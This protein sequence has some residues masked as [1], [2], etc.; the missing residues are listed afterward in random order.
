M[1]LDAEWWGELRRFRVL[2]EAG[3]SVSEIARE[4]DLNRRT[5]AKYLEPNNPTTSDNST[6]NHEDHDLRL[7]Y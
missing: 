4:T 7:E 2:H 6:A 3:M 1:L 5:V